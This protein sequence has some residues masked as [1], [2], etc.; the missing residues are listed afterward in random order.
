MRINNGRHGD[1]PWRGA[2]T[3][4]R[5]RSCC[6][7]W[8]LWCYL[9]ILARYVERTSYVWNDV[10]SALAAPGVLLGSPYELLLGVRTV[11]GHDPPSALCLSRTL[12]QQRVTQ[13][14]TQTCS[15]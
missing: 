1:P 13:Q 4:G 12:A 3:R 6:V 9:V 2:I 14:R 15:T 5:R 7:I 8:W 10:L 11:D